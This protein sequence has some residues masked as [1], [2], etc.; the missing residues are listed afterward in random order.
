[1]S[2]TSHIVKLNQS[3]LLLV[4]GM[5]LKV[6]LVKNDIVGSIMS[7]NIRIDIL[8]KSLVVFDKIWVTSSQLH[9][10]DVSLRSID[11]QIALVDH[12]VVYPVDFK[13]YQIFSSQS[14]H[15]VP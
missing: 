4:V 10:S 13:L 11:N 8:Q 6:M 14:L 5:N 7:E 2:V 9:Q 3:S 15:H 1:M 12:S